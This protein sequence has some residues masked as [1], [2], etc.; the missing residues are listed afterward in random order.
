MKLTVTIV[1]TGLIGGSLGMAL[2]EKGLAAK[3]IGVEPNVKTTCGGS[4]R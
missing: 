4:V 3:V 1:G 2:K